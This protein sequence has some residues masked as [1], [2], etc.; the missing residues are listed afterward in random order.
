[1]AKSA[2]QRSVSKTVRSTRAPKRSSVKR[3]QPQASPA[4]SPF[5]SFFQAT[6]DYLGM[7]AIVERE[8]GRP[9]TLSDELKKVEALEARITTNPSARDGADCFELVR[10]LVYR[11][12]APLLDYF[13][14]SENM[15]ERTKDKN[16]KH[17]NGWSHNAKKKTVLILYNKA[18]GRTGERIK[19]IREQIAT[20]RKEWN[21][22]LDRRAIFGL[23]AELRAEGRIK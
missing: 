23:L 17:N 13:L 1:M 22:S 2:K 21:L 11:E 9:F 15:K 7:L 4:E 12:S 14:H 10:Q 6:R 3:P 5:G 19:Q 18:T 8:D 20:N 16:T